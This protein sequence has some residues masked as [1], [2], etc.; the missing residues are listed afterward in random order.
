MLKHFQRHTFPEIDTVQDPSLHKSVIQ[1][2]SV[3]AYTVGC[4]CGAICAIFVSNP[5]GR[6]RSILVG[7]SIMIVG[8]ILMTSATTLGQFVAARVITG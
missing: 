6:R 3:G 5:L 4:L 7:S 1:G 2:I 8:G